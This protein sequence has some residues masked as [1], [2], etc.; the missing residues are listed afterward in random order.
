VGQAAPLI[1]GTSVYLPA[2]AT[3]RRTD[4]DPANWGAADWAET[5]ADPL[6]DPVNPPAGLLGSEAVLSSPAKAGALVVLTIRFTY[7]L[8]QYGGDGLADV[9][10]LRDFAAAFDP[11]AAGSKLAW[12]AL[13]GEATV[14]DV[15]G[16]PPYRVSPS[17][18]STG[19]S[20]AFASGVLPVLRLLSPA[21][22][23]AGSFALDAPCLASPLVAN[24]RLYALSTTGTLHVFQGT[25]APPG[26]VGGMSPSGLELAASPATLSWTEAEPGATYAVRID[27]DGEVLMDWDVELAVSGTATACP[28]LGGGAVHTWAVR[29]RDAD[30]A[31]GPWQYGGVG[32]DVP[33][34][35]PGGLAATPKHEKV[36][37]TWTRSPS[38]GVTG[39]RLTV[40]PAGGPPGPA[41]DLGDVTSTVVPGLV[42]GAVYQ[43][44]VRAVTATAVSLPAT[45]LAAPVPLIT[46]GGT[47]FDTLQAAAAGALPGQT[48]Q[49]GEDVF[50]LTGTLALPAGVSLS[51]V[52]AHVTRIL[53]S[54]PF[55]MVVASGGNTVRLVTL[56]G[57]SLGVRAVGAGV[58]V[59]NCVVRDQSGDALVADAP[60]EAVNDTIVGNAGAAM[61]ATAMSTARNLIAQSNGAGLVGSIASSYNDVVGAPTGGTGDFSAAV[62]FRD[63]AS[64]DYREAARQ[65]SLDAGRP[66]DDFSQEPAPNGGR[67]NLGAFGNTALAATTDAAPASS[68]HDSGCLASAVPGAGGAWIWI[69]LVLLLRRRR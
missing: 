62:A 33:V 56:A 21:G 58:V 39:Y 11:A 34:D 43:F 55:E 13:L 35:P 38:P 66:A 18:V 52:N 36:V 48:I 60:M 14:P 1:D 27:D 3:L 54:G 69:P 6:F 53:A 16:V 45:L 37:L 2:G 9:R 5:L 61:R 10:I 26:A 49:L 19:S 50:T 42:N 25:N 15:N 31:R 20:I 22:A 46:V 32:V 44:E 64:G 41:S 47:G 30:G 28:P 24:A 17:P 40:G 23:D 8:D 29:A 68:T 4:L 57:G 63:A 67:I 7:H 59:A 51:G 12:Q 65:P